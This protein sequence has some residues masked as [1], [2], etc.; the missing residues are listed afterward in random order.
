MAPDKQ[1]ATELESGA[2]SW[3]N[4]P[5]WLAVHFRIRGPDDG[6]LIVGAKYEKAPVLGDVDG[7]SRR[8]LT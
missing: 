1:I 2:T 5:D 7:Q 6:V 8:L 3:V 4:A